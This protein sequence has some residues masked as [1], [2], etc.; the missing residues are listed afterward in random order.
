MGGILGW[1]QAPSALPAP[2]SATGQVVGLEEIP[3][4]LPSSSSLLSK[5]G[6]RKF[7]ASLKIW[8]LICHFERHVDILIHAGAS[9]F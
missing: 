1:T 2:L 8:I 7:R 9:V 5:V 6:N 3:H 4:S